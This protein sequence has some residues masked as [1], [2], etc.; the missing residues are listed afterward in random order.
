MSI[1]KRLINVKYLANS[2]KS[3]PKNKLSAIMSITG[4]GLRKNMELI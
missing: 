3:A 4:S 2:V 1:S